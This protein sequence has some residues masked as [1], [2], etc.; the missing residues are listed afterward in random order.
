MSTRRV[1]GTLI[2][3]AIGAVLLTQCADAPEE[4]RADPRAEELAT[5]AVG[6]TREEEAEAAAISAVE[7]T[8]YTDQGQPYGCTEDCSGHD[9]GY[10]WAQ[11]NGLTDPDE[12]GGN[13]QSF[14]EGCRSF[15]EAYEEAYQDASGQE[16]Q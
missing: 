9:A 6:E 7:G 5:E 10:A 16:P 4:V 12:C 1:F 11:N 14:I 15:G 8:T 3:L 2:A 13:S